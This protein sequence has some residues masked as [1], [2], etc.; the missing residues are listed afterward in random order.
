M[1]NAFVVLSKRVAFIILNL[2][3]KSRVVYRTH[4]RER[5]DS[6]HIIDEV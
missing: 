5:A 3:N 1:N 2:L 4:K 6:H